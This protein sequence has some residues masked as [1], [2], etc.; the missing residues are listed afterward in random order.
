MQVKDCLLVAGAL[1]ESVHDQTVCE[2]CTA[3]H[4]V[5]LSVYLLSHTH[6]LAWNNVSTQQWMWLQLCG[7]WNWP[8]SHIS[9]HHIMFLL[10][11]FISVS[12]SVLLSI[13]QFYRGTY[14]SGPPVGNHSFGLFLK[15][16]IVGGGKVPDTQKLKILYI[17]VKMKFK[18]QFLCHFCIGKYVGNKLCRCVKKDWK[19]Q[20]TNFKIAFRILSRS[21]LLVPFICINFLNYIVTRNSHLK[22]HKPTVWMLS[23]GL[24]L[25]PRIENSK[26]HMSCGVTVQLTLFHNNILVYCPN[27]VWE[28]SMRDQCKVFLVQARG[29]NLKMFNIILPYVPFNPICLV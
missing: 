13:L 3:R 18:M 11:I 15:N 1:W 23:W 17:I 26:H 21:L 9:L 28:F 12:L 8:K 4:S 16:W 25:T 22:S 7:V 19:H 27:T 6:T 2:S 24:L 10:C 5:W 20:K 14:K 29:K